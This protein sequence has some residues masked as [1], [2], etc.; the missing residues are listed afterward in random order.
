MDNQNCQKCKWYVVILSMLQIYLLLR[1]ALGIT[2]DGAGWPMI[3]T[4]QN[5]PCIQ[6]DPAPS[7]R[8]L[9]LSHRSTSSLHSWLQSWSHYSSSGSLLSSKC[10]LTRTTTTSGKTKRSIFRPTW[11]NFVVFVSFFV[12]EGEAL[13]VFR[14]ILNLR[15]RQ[16][17]YWHLALF[18]LKTYRDNNLFSDWFGLAMPPIILTATVPSLLGLSSETLLMIHFTSRLS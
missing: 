3:T 13:K 5:I 10:G 4:T 8:L 18:L 17:S 11:P 7:E 14:A 1:D 16:P 6:M 15:K 12:E 2:W 9:S